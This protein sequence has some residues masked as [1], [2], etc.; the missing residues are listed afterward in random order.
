MKEYERLNNN[1]KLLE[2]HN[3]THKPIFHL[4]DG[5]THE[6]DLI[7]DI[8]SDCRGLLNKIENGTL[9]ELP[10]KVGDTVYIVANIDCGL[11]KKHGIVEGVVTEIEITIDK[12]VI[13]S[14]IYVEHPF[15]YSERNPNL[16]INRYIFFPDELFLTKAEAEKKLKELQG[17]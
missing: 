1:L 14:R 17:E 9:I 13:A 11:A 2:L 10:C 7:R 4:T 5:Q 3:E 12:N 15:I 6:V 8:I 16:I